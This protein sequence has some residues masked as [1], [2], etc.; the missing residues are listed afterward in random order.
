METVTSPM[1]VS[2]LYCWKWDCRPNPSITPHVFLS[3][4][5]IDRMSRWHK[6]KLKESV[7]TGTEEILEPLVIV[8][9]KFWMRSC[10]WSQQTAEKY[11]YQENSIGK[12][13]HQKANSWKDGLKA[14]K[15]WWEYL[16]LQNTPGMY[17]QNAESGLRNDCLKKHVWKNNSF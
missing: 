1:S 2:V 16:A 15:S 6:S 9:D 14:H 5:Y 10:A 3:H 7:L 11:V 13:N 8:F 12:D 17:T 4:V